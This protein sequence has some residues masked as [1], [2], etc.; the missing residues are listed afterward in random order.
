MRIFLYR[1]GRVYLA[2]KNALVYLFC[3][4]RRGI[5]FAR[6]RRPY[7][8]HSDSLWYETITA[9]QI[10][11][12]LRGYAGEEKRLL[13][14]GCGKGYFIY[15]AKQAGFRFVDGVELNDGLYRVAQRNMR[16]LHMKDVRLFLQDA[17]NFAGL[18]GYDILYMFN[19]FGMLTM[20]RFARSVRESLARKPRRLVV[21]YAHPMQ[22]GQWEALPEFRLKET[23][24]VKRFPRNI[25]VFYYESTCKIVDKSFRETL[26]GCLGEARQVTGGTG[27]GGASETKYTE[28]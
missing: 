25:T 12:I 19:P 7:G 9:R 4:K 21:I 8:A 3:E 11:S 2:V 14:V 23:R 10:Q 13:D 18:D 16:A 6:M 27:D 15:C 17:A 26:A 22:R 1:L 20:H 28:Q 5:D 24:T